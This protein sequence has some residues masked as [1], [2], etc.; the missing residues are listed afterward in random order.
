MTKTWAKRI[1]KLESILRTRMHSPVVFRYGSVKRL[2]SD[3]SG[4]R[5]VAVSSS[6]PTA[7]AHVERCEFEERLGPAPARDEPTFHVYLTLE[8]EKGSS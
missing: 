3:P 4:E 1:Q 5:H 7:L 6:E 8:D 2:P